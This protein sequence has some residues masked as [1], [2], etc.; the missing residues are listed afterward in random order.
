MVHSLL[1]PNKFHERDVT[2]VHPP[3]E[4]L[5]GLLYRV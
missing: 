2:P 1:V 3:T 5:S 4:G